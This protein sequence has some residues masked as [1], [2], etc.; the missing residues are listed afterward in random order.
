MQ[1]TAEFKLDFVGGWTESRYVAAQ[2]SLE[3]F[4]RRYPLVLPRA[5]MLER[6]VEAARL[7]EALEKF[8]LLSDIPKLSAL[9]VRKRTMLAVV[10]QA[11]IDKLGLAGTLE[12]Y[13]AV[14]EPALD[15]CECPSPECDPREICPDELLER[16]AGV[17]QLQD[18]IEEERLEREER[19]EREKHEEREQREQPA[20][21]ARKVRA[22]KAV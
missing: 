15:E 13:R 16:L 6:R 1:A 17:K 10:E 22:G 11:D 7:R 12:Q 3:E 8:G 19:E 4:V 14:F 18:M 5:T 9:G 2:A 21:K 20:R